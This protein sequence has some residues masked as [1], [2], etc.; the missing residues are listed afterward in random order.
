VISALT[1]LA[2]PTFSL[3]DV[4]RH[5]PSTSSKRRSIVT[6][7]LTNQSYRCYRFRV[8]N[9]S[10]Q[11]LLSCKAQ[12]KS[13]TKDSGEKE[14]L[15]P[16]SLRRSQSGNEVFPLRPGEEKL[17]DLLAV[18]LKSTFPA[19]IA[20]VDETWPEF[21]MHGSAIEKAPSLLV[22]QVLSESRMVYTN[23]SASSKWSTIFGASCCSETMACCRSRRQTQ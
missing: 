15:V 18:P 1:H 14:V 2:A 3:T 5:S 8:L 21:G 7:R 22:V 11:P 20:A 16:F 13:V 19:K 10:A 12:L 9:A 6:A 17:V 4:T 23:G